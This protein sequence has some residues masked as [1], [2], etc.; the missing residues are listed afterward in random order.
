MIPEGVTGSAA[1]TAPDALEPKSRQIFD[2]GLVLILKELHDRLDREVFAAYGWPADLS[3]DDI[4]AR[5]VALNAERAKEEARGKVRWLRPD[6]QIPRFGS[7]K[8]K[9]ELELVGGR[10]GDGEAAPAGPKPSFPEN[11]LAQTVAITAMLASAA[12]PMS[13]AAIAARFKQGRRIEPKVLEV[14][15]ALSRMSYAGSNDNGVTFT[16]QRVG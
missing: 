14:L 13:A 2:D 4:L 5:L 15:Q 11:E 16:L 6:Y 3:D 8:E 1:G 7:V 9:A 10:T 12:Q